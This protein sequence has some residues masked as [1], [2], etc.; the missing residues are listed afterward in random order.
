VCARERVCVKDVMVFLLDYETVELSEPPM[1][2]SR[3]IARLNEQPQSDD[4]YIRV[5][6]YT[7]HAD[8]AVLFFHA[9]LIC[10]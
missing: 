8:A 1:P 9:H 6:N 10:V 3:K 7:R 4:P 5:E 2:A